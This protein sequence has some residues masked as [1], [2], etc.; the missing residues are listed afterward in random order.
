MW[1]IEVTFLFCRFVIICVNVSDEQFLLNRV[2]D[3]TIDIFA[4]ASILSRAS[5]SISRGDA[6]AQYETNIVTVFCNEV[7]QNQK[8]LK[9]I[10]ISTCRF[11]YFIS[12]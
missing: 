7:K 9:I 11:R 2:A 12:D 6:S 4:M 8:G 5:R 3:S 10:I 1:N